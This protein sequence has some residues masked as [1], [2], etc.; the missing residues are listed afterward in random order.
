MTADYAANIRPVEFKI[1]KRDTSSPRKINCCHFS[2]RDGKKKA[3]GQ[4]MFTGL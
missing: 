1:L 4:M 3:W 2:S